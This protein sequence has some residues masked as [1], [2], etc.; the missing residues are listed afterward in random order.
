MLQFIKPNWPAPENVKAYTTTRTGGFSKPPYE[1][2]NLALHVGDHQ[3]DVLANRKKLKQVLKLPNEPVWLMQQH[4]NTVIFADAPTTLNADGAYTKAPNTVC[5]I[6]TADCL[7]I[8]LCNTKGTEI[9]ALHGGWRSLSQGIIESGL[10]KFSGD[11]K[12]IL[13]WLAPAIGPEVFEVGQEVLDVF[14]EMFPFFLK[15]KYIRNNIFKPS[16]NH[17]WL[18]N[19]YQFARQEF[20]RL[21]VHQVYGGNFC[22]HSDSK[23]FYSY[24]RDGQTG[25]MASLIWMEGKCSP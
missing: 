12:D 15:Q 20:T 9:S 23:R 4:E 5:V 21:G 16:S 14:T 24:R 10:Q 6:L 2:F 1:S 17:Q 22:T 13:V 18:F 19:I 25:R 11:S 8:L 3:N 7:P